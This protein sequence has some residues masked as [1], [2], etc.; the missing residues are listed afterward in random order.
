VLLLLLLLLLLTLSAEAITCGPCASGWPAPPSFS[1]HA[2]GCPAA[3]TQ[4]H[5]ETERVNTGMQCHWA[6]L[7]WLRE[8]E[9]LHARVCRTHLLLG[10]LESTLVLAN[11]QQL[12]HT[13]LV[14]SEASHLTH[15]VAHKLDALAQGP[16]VPSLRVCGHRKQV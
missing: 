15:N 11:L 3:G 1:F 2:S 7:G 8:R 5:I 12:H 13:P 16:G 10:D 4:T 14:G 6:W 9:S